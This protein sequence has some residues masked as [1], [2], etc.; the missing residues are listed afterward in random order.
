MRSKIILSVLFFLWLNIPLH[1]QRKQQVGQT[2]SEDPMITDTYISIGTGI[3]YN[4]G[5]LGVQFEKKFTQSFAG[6]LGAGL[7]SWG[8]KLTLGTRMY[9]GETRSSAFSFSYTYVT[10]ASGVQANLY[11]V[12]SAYLT[13]QG[14]QIPVKYDMNPVSVVNASWLKYWKMGKKSRF[15]IELGYSFLVN[16][17]TEANYTLKDKIVLTD[18]SKAAFKIIQPGGIMVGIGFSFGL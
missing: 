12:D 7:G 4:T 14:K 6:Y 16:S 8:Y 10:G 13:G 5:I 15:N 18:A 1:A 2:I 9:Y 3:N 17:N 11:V